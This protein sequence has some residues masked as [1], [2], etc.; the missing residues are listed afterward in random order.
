MDHVKE[1]KKMLPDQLRYLIS[2]EDPPEELRL[3]AG[4]QAAVARAGKLSLTPLICTKELMDE[5]LEKLT[6]RSY[7]VHSETIAHI[8]LDHCP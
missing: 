8:I 1:L 5:T 2:E 7:Y 3:Y 4:R 6:N